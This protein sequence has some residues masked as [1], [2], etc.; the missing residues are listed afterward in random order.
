MY[1]RRHIIKTMVGNE[2]RKGDSCRMETPREEQGTIWRILEH[3]SSQLTLSPPKSHRSLHK[4]WG[5][6]WRRTI[7]KVRQF[8]TPQAEHGGRKVRGLV[9]PHRHVKKGKAG[10]LESRRIINERRDAFYM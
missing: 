9:K 6:M 3:K 5:V 4:N 8:L 7:K 2:S 10:R 1:E